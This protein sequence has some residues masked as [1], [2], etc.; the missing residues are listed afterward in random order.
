MIRILGTLLIIFSF[1]P[2]SAQDVTGKWQNFNHDGEVNSIIEVYKKDGKIYGRVDRIMREKDRDRVCTECEGKLKD[3]PIE[4]M[5]LMQGLTKDGEEYSGGT[6]VD[7]K[8]GKEYRCKIWLD[9]NDPNKLNVRGYL[10]VF[11]KTK[12]WERA[13]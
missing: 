6:I 9:E 4:G 12:V 7:P 8:T 11:Y 5:V 13:E 3:Q 10:A 2:V 1:L